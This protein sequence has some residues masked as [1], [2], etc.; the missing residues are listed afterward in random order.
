MTSTQLPEQI[1]AS[2][3]QDAINRV[4][5][6]F[7]STTSD[8]MNELLQNSRRSG[9][10]R[11]DITLEEGLITVADDG[12]GISNPE[13]ILSFGL[14]G[15]E[16]QTTQS[17]HPAGMGLYA[18]AR[19]EQVAIRSKSAGAD[20][21]QV[22]LTPDHFV[23]K[24]PAPIER[25]IDGPAK[26]GTTVCF[27]GNLDDETAIRNSVRYYPLPVRINGADAEKGDFLEHAQ[28]IEEWQGIRIGVYLNSWPHIIDHSADLNFHGVIVGE[29]RL[30]QVRAIE[31]RWFT[32]A[33]VRECPHLELTLPARRE[34]VEN[35]FMDEFRQACRTAIYRAMTRQPEPVDVP[36]KV[37]RAA[38]D[39]GVVL[40]DASP[41]LM[42]WQPSK[43]KEKYNHN[44]RQPVA[45]QH[46]IVMNISL[47]T[48]D[49]QSLARA[50]QKAGIMNRLFEPNQELAGYRWYDELDMAEEFRI[51]ITDQDGDHD[52]DKVREAGNGLNNQ[53]PD[54]ITITLTTT[55][56]AVDEPGNDPTIDLP[57]DVAFENDE[58]DYT[59]E[60]K[61]LV[62]QGSDITSNE[63]TNLMMNSFFSPNAD[64]DSDSFDTQ[65]M[66]HEEAY[67]KT[68]IELLQSKDDAII[69]AII[70]AIN[71]QVMYELP[72]G[73]VATIRVK[74]RE[75]I[76]VTL[77]H[78]A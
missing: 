44:S 64:Y 65:E 38:A 69:A 22:N 1:R 15:W 62:T 14:T 16:Q 17:E 45:G 72:L 50:A 8:I 46:P 67:E 30:P 74:R 23:G 34:V 55:T 60:I 48:P 54:A 24:L 73:T 20:T 47:S 57:T 63:L 78:D 32:Q 49:Q 33:D 41:R 36:K 19:R 52:L 40:P 59:D 27:I 77:E 11:V 13:A 71:R 56:N 29:C 4:S 66:N 70:T 21:W 51:T 5:E 76:Q 28:H 53:R 7:N 31:S 18:L 58:E 42:P 43:A 37:Q 35:P 75:P 12:N 25:I 6:F 39:V 68:A 2:I 61:P 9:A 26:S 3:H 10:S